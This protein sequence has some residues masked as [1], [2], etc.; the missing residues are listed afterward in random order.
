MGR[1][2]LHGAYHLVG[3]TDINPIDT[4]VRLLQSVKGYEGKRQGNKIV[5]DYLIQYIWEGCLEEFV[6]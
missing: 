3:E 2:Y 6:F 1:P 4:Y 5:G